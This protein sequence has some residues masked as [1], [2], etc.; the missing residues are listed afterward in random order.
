[1]NSMKPESLT[2]IALACFTVFVIISFCSCR[3]TNSIY[4]G[5]YDIEC[6]EG[7]LAGDTVRFY[8]NVPGN[9][10]KLW[11]ISGGDSSNNFY[12]LD[13][14]PQHV[15]TKRGLYT[16]VIIINDD[17]ANLKRKNPGLSFY[18]N[19]PYNAAQV[20]M[21]GGSRWWNVSLDSLNH[22]NTATVTFQRYK[23]TFAVNVINSSTIVIKNDTLR[24]MS[25]DQYYGVYKTYSFR[26]AASNGT[27]LSWQTLDYY[28]DQD[29]IVY[30][31]HPYQGGIPSF[32]AGGTPGSDFQAAVPFG[33]TTNYYSHK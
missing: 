8:S 12:T 10:K 3:K 2:K 7:L 18:I 28:F 19:Q 32:D 23:D 14:V 27:G 6:S 22:N 25:Q 21:M 9:F 30:S 24:D 17:T 16:A 33:I 1:M 31:S 5:P 15:F 4:D 20:A 29:S 13:E 26:G 11:F